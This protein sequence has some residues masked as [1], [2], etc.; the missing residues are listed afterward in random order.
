MTKRLYN[1]DFL[2]F[3]FALTLC[4]M[5]LTMGMGSDSNIL[6][7]IAVSLAPAQI[8][9]D[10]FFIISGFVGG[11]NLQFVFFFGG[12]IVIKRMPGVDEV[13]RGVIAF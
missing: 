10:F 8:L 9:T 5:H 3:L 7:D 2:R 6:K 13:Y 4:V 1:I 11:E 12:N